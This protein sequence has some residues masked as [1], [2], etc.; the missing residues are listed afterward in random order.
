MAVFGLP[1]KATKSQPSSIWK[2]ASQINPWLAG[3]DGLEALGEVLPARWALASAQHQQVAGDLFV[4]VLARSLSGDT[5]VLEVQ[6]GQSNHDHLGKLLTYCSIYKAQ[7]AVWVVGDARPEHIEAINLL[8]QSD[9]AEFFLV[10]LEA[11]SVDGSPAAPLLTLITGPAVELKTAGHVKA[12]LKH[13]D[14]ARI[15]FWKDFLSEAVKHDP[16]FTS[17][18]A[19]ASNRLGIPSSRLGIRY[20]V[21]LRQHTC[22]VEMVVLRGRKMKFGD[23]LL[24]MTE[25][26][27]SKDTLDVQMKGEGVA[28]NVEWLYGPNPRVRVVLPGGG[29]EDPDNWPQVRMA[30]LATLDALIAATGPT[31][32][33]LKSRP[34][35]S[36]GVQDEDEEEESSADEV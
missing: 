16:R 30:V 1:A 13:R 28:P 17:K 23:P 26:G 9:I 22:S 15:A 8:N 14:A 3:D 25:V 24:V 34:L 33:S 21:G 36:P 27:E 31:L 6:L 11:V 5:V 4:D 20:V 12:E 35:V 7:A 18:T 10:K 2:E 19:R 32:A 29:Y